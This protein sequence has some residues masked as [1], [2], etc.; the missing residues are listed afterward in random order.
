M[1]GGNDWLDGATADGSDLD[2]LS[3]VLST[4]AITGVPEADVSEPEAFEDSGAALNPNKSLSCT[5]DGLVLF[6]D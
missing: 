3:A 1:E 6:L 4:V 5:E 2:C